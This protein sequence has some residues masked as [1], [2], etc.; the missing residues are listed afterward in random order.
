MFQSSFTVVEISNAII[1]ADFLSHFDILPVLRNRH[2]VD[3]KT[4]LESYGIPAETDA[5][6]VSAVGPSSPYASLL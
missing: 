2:V 4:L 5:P 3:G 1:G 6:T